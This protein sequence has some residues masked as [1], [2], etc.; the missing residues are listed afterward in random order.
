MTIL[1]FANNALSA[2]ASPIT[3]ADTTI[4]LQAGTGSLF[5]TP[6]SGQVFLATIYNSSST[7]YEI[8]LV[9]A[10]SGDTVTVV[11]A[12]ENTTAQTWLTGNSFGM[13]PTKGTM[14]SFVQADQL[15]NGT[16]TYAIGGGTANALTAQIPSDLTTIADGFTFIVKATANNTGATTLQLTLGSTVFSAYPILKGNGYPLITGDIWANYP[17]VLTWSSTL[18]AFVMQNPGTSVVPPVYSYAVNYLI[19]AGGGG[20]GFDSFQ[21]SGGGGAGGMI[22]GTTS[23]TSGLTYAITVGSGGAINSAG[24]N[25]SAFG[26]TAIGGGSGAGN[27]N[28]SVING[29]SGG[30]QCVRDNPSEDFGPGSGTTGQ[31]FAGGTGGGYIGGGGGGAS[32]SGQGTSGGNGI[33]SSITGSSITYAGGGGG[34]NRQVGSSGA[35]GAGGGGYNNINGG[36]NTGGGGAGGGSDPGAWGGSQGGSGIAIF[37]YKNATQRGS[38]G[39]ITSYTVGSDTYWVHTFLSSNTYTA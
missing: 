8:V 18:T 4:Y 34:G 26:F 3:S 21:G 20:G 13:Y 22:T 25:S 35:A 38:G 14:Q 24:Q 19:V 2:L 31:G 28:T 32:Q 6:T 7:S 27:N 12:Q 16:Y 33:S 39:T 37:S 23:V 9:T 17:C 29:G 30:G 36:S 15:Q 1:Q 10:R 11:R 5:P